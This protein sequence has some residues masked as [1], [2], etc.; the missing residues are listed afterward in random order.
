MALLEA[1]RYHADVLETF[2]VKVFNEKAED[3]F[4]IGSDIE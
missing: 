2:F 1:A 3:T 4:M